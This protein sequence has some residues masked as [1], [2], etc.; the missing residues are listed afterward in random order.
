MRAARADAARQP[1]TPWRRR[2][3]RR[4]VVHALERIAAGDLTV[5]LDT[6]GRGEAARVAVAINTVVGRLETTAV[7][8]RR[9]SAELNKRWQ[10][11]H[12][13]S[14]ALQSTAEQT[15]TQAAA[16]TESSRLIAENAQAVAAAT[17][18]LALTIREIAQNAAVTSDS[19]QQG[20]REAVASSETVG[21]LARASREVG[22]LVKVIAGIASQTRLLALNARIEAASVGEAGKGFAV[23][24]SEVKTLAAEATAA[25]DSASRVSAGIDQGANSVATAIA[26]IT[27]TMTNVS[28]NQASIVAM[29]E[30]QSS[31]AQEIGHRAAETASGSEEIVSNIES[32]SRISRRLA[33]GGSDGLN[34]AS[35]LAELEH[36]LSAATAD[37]IVSDVEVA[38]VFERVA[39]RRAVVTGSATTVKDSVQ[40]EGLHEFRYVGTWLHSEANELSGDSD[41]YSCVPGDTAV[42]R[43]RGRK[44]RFYGVTDARHGKVGLSIDGV[45][46]VV[47][48][49]YSPNRAHGVLLWTSP[50]LPSGEHVL[51]VRVLSETNPLARYNWATVDR[52]EVES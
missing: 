46:D 51:T 40:G 48:D 41:S 12:Q 39:R 20:T 37:L 22:E 29:V 44:V 35:A 9:A 6:I 32:I 23:V 52:V 31:S 5:R 45:P 15:S 8:V 25:A 36:M 49:E 7:T 26:G 24:A 11:I 19:A 16:V 28:T 18:E 3:Q 27:S 30:Q 1:I 33:Y 38:Q 42:L 4:A 2:G 10:A 47:V 34:V 13:L 14:D 50:D 43:F 21:E 17:E